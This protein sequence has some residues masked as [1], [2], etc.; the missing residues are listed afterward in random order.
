MEGMALTRAGVATTAD[1][2]TRSRFEG[3]AVISAGA[4]KEAGFNTRFAFDESLTPS[5]M[6][7]ALE[8]R[9]RLCQA[10]SA[11]QEVST[12]I[13]MWAKSGSSVVP[14]MLGVGTCNG[15]CT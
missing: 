3:M 10:R 9:L 2:N 15:M 4:A 1:F 7:G 13:T 14:G 11:N 8:T 6:D 5:A 12:A